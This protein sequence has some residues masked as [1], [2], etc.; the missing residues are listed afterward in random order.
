MSDI[1]FQMSDVISKISNVRC[2]IAM[3]D[4][5]CPISMSDIGSHILNFNV[6]I[7]YRSYVLCHTSYIRCQMSDF[8]CLMVLCQKSGC[9]ILFHPALLLLNT[10]TDRFDLPNGWRH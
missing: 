5:R 8:S 9:V 1:R 4:V 6:N 7:A 3:S 10:F 2:Q